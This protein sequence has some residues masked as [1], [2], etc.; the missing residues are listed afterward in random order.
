MVGLSY[1]SVPLYRAFC[2]AT[3]YGGTV[4]QT[5]NIEAKLAAREAAPNP[6]REARAAARELRVW[7]SSDVDDD[8]PWTFKPTQRYVTV[9]PGESALAFFTAHNLR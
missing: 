2:Q 7:F 8:M 3:G 5:H 9:R 4:S 6:E 1:A